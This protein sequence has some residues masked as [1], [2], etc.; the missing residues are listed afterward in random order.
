MQIRFTDKAIE[1]LENIIDIHLDYSGELAATKFSS[2]V[3]SKLTK[4]LKYPL[5]GFPKPLLEGR[6]YLFRATIIN[7]NYKMIYYVEADTIW[8]AAFWDMRMNPN[9]LR[10]MI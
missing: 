10:R 2:L 9:K 5:I 6:K 4:L 1:H 7:R 3:D 8:V